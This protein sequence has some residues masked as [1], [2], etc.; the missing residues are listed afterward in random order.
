MLNIIRVLKRREI[1]YITGEEHVSKEGAESILS[2]GRSEGSLRR[3]RQAN[4]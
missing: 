2:F 1:V 4:R 3:R